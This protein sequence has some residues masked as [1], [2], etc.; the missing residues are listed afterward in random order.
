MAAF[1]LTHSDPSMFI[2]MG[3]SSLEAAHIWISIPFSTF[4]IVSLLGNFMVLSVVGKK[5]TLHK[6][7]YLLL[8]MLA[9]TDIITPTFVVPKALSIFWFNLKGITMAACLTQMFFLQTVS[10]VHSATL[11]TMA[12]D[13]YIA[14]CN[15][16]R[17][18]IILSNTQIA[19]LGLVGLIRAVLFILPLPLI[20]S[21]QPFCANSI[22]PHMQCEYIA[23][24]KMA[25]GDITVIRIYSL[26]LMF[27]VMG[28]DLTFIA[29]SYGLIITVVLRFS[30]KKAHQKALNTCTTHICMMLTYYTPGLFS[31]ITYWF[32]QGITPHVH[33][34][35]ADLYLLIP[36]MLNP[37][38]YGIRNKEL[39]DKVGKYSCCRR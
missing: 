35:L 22:I 23:V 36:P 29:L 39:R 26:V 34:I 17:Y 6:P 12:F 30:S 21:R 33:I 13:C 18:A 1:N 38:I 19:K 28:F 16:L 37:I 11:V 24:V 10:V 3:I 5:Q 4:Y 31:N 9:L 15:S 27:V 25:C 2:I 32:G 8:C 20:L 14:I 7:M